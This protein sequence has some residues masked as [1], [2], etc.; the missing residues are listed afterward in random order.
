MNWLEPKK[1]ENNKFLP[2]D[3]IFISLLNAS[4]IEDYNTE[5][6][7]YCLHWWLD[8]GSADLDKTTL[9]NISKKRFV[10]GVNK[11]LDIIRPHFFDE[12]LMFISYFN[13][14]LVKIDEKSL[15]LVEHRFEFLRYDLKVKFVFVIDEQ[16][17]PFIYFIRA[18]NE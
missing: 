2:G 3:L 7:R 5:I 8:F 4:T 9:S 18:N 13:I 10:T 14:P 12:P 6:G 17:D 16:Q 15:P 1:W 11:K